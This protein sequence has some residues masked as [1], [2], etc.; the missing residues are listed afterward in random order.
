MTMYT[1]N[2]W[3]FRLSACRSKWMVVRP[4]WRDGRGPLT[5]DEILSEIGPHYG[6]RC[7]EAIHKSESAQ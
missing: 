2:A 3:N 7:I 1:E 5:D 4:Y 6:Q